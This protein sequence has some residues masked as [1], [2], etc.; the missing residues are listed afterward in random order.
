MQF[1]GTTICSV[2]RQGRVAMGGDGQVSFGNTVMKANARKV[3][4]MYHDRVLAGFAGGTAD[5]FT[6]FERFEGKL[7]KHQ[8]NLTRAAVELAKD[9]RSDRAL[10]RLEALL[11]VADTETSFVISGTGDVIEPE[12]GLM[13][14]GSGG[15]YAQAAACA[16]LDHTEL[17][18]R[19]IVEVAL[20]IAAEICIY[21]N[22]NLTLEELE[23]AR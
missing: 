8:G 11:A 10:R 20:G 19:A 13:A 9:W 1:E 7:E 18:A 23:S 21:T 16:L 3:R 17:G 15:P 2:R 14:I 4:R 22:S 12:R 5:A 6:L